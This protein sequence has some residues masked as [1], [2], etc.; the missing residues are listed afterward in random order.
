VGISR[1]YGAVSSGKLIAARLENSLKLKRSLLD[2]EQS[3]RSGQLSNLQLAQPSG[4]SVTDQAALNAI[5][6][7]APFAPLAIVLSSSGIVTRDF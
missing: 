6:Q 7:S 3:N 1:K 5:Q 4:F 2:I